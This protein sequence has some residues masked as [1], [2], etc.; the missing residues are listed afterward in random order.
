MHIQAT[1]L[2]PNSSIVGLLIHPPVSERPRLPFHLAILLD[3][4]ASMIGSRI[5]S[6]Q[7]TLHALI[8]QMAD[9]DALTLLEYNSKAT[10]LCTG[11]SDKAELRQITDSLKCQQS[12]NLEEALHLFATL[13]IPVEHPIHTVCILTDGQNTDGLQS[14]TE[15]QYLAKI[16]IPKGI[17][18]CTLGYGDD[19]NET[20]L[21][22]LA[23]TTRGTYNYIGHTEMVPVTVGN[24][25]GAME[26]EVAKD[27]EVLLEEADRCLEPLA[28]SEEQTNCFWMGSLFAEKPQWVVLEKANKETPLIV[29]WCNR[30]TGVEEQQSVIVSEV[31]EENADI[32]IQWYRVR[33]LAVMNKAKKAIENNIHTSYMSCTQELKQLSEEMYASRV[34]TA[35][36]VIRMMAQMHELSETL[37]NPPQTTFPQPMMSHFL[38]RQP[39]GG[40]YF[41]SDNNRLLTRLTSDM[42]TMTVQRGV[43]SVSQD[44]GHNEDPDIF[45]SPVQRGVSSALV[46]GFSQNPV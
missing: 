13:S 10:V 31:Q 40:G 32:L 46:H 20:L 4:S 26:S 44:P 1:Y 28:A 14:T 3:T 5:K 45:T 42:T 30:F 12:T 43:L 15:L 19:H 6:V 16:R 8:E 34:N 9:T 21:Q 17:P 11:C 33:C 36:L 2:K 23:L 7:R 37:R 29:K 38:S 27:A 35:S 18:I 22:N 25:V 41:S 24:I 39:S